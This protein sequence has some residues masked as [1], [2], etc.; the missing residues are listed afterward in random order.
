MANFL[1]VGCIRNADGT[2]ATPRA[3]MDELTRLRSEVVRLTELH[4]L[5]QDKVA[6]L[7]SVLGAW[8]RGFAERGAQLER[9][10]ERADMAEM[11]VAR[12]IGERDA[13]RAEVERL[14]GELIPPQPASLIISRARDKI[15]ALTAELEALRA[16][17]ARMTAKVWSLETQLADLKPRPTGPL[18]PVVLEIGVEIDKIDAGRR[19]T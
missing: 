11:A 13:L 4:Q 18:T 12:L 10:T 3:I 9:L 1:L 8:Q 19:A 14:K 6:D 16:D 2:I 15:A 7:T 17:A 5:Y